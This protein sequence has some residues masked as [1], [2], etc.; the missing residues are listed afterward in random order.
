MLNGSHFSGKIRIA[1][2]LSSDERNVFIIPRVNFSVASVNTD[3][4][5]AAATLGV[6]QSIDLQV[7]NEPDLGGCM[8]KTHRGMTMKIP[9]NNV[10]LCFCSINDMAPLVF[11]SA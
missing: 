11:H 4:H 3:F 9:Q 2:S 7:T 6:T 8:F 1:Q 10:V 5:P